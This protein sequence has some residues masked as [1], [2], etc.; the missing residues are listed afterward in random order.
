MTV[1]GGFVDGGEAVVL[2]S[3]RSFCGGVRLVCWLCLCK[4]GSCLWSPDSGLL[5]WPE[6]GDGDRGEGGRW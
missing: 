6:L 2:V 3:W 1:A 5:Q 4:S